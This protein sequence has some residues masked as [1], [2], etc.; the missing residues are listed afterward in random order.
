MPDEKTRADSIRTYLTGAGSDGGAQTDPDASLG[1]FRSST[2]AAL[3]GISI[4]SPISGITVEDVAAENGEGVGSLE[5]SGSSE[6]KWTPPGGTQGVAVTIANGETKI[7]EGG[8]VG[9][10][11]KW[12]RVNRTSASPLSGTATVTLAD[13]FNDVVGFDN[14]SSAEASA[15]DDEYRAVMMKNENPTQIDNLKVFIKT[16]GTQRVSDTTQ[17]P[18]AGAGTIE[19]T[20]SFADWPD[21]GWCHIK[22]N[23]G[24]TREVVYYSSRTATVLTVPS[25]GRARLGTSAGAGAADDT[26]DAVSGIRIGHEAPSGQPAGFIQ[27]IADEDTAPGAITFNIEITAALGVQIGSLATGNIAGLWIHRETPA[28]AVADANVLHHIGYQF[29]AS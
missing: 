29:D 11:N 18:G 24:T 12:I 26:L 14:V 21:Q 28:G 25:T 10:F 7:V 23:G 19:T 16:L 4:T 3:M 1:N 5:A 8:G 2:L 13:V 22:D 27:T 6:L 17:L 15:G 20:G 9:E